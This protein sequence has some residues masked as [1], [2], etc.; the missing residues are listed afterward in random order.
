[1]MSAPLEACSSVLRAAFVVCAGRTTLDRVFERGALRL[2]RPHGAACEGMIVNTGGGIVAGDRLALDMSLSAQAEVTVTT[3]AAEKIYGSTGPTA[4]IETQLRLGA[5][6]RLDWLPQETILFDGARLDRRFA[7]DMA[8][9]AR[10]VAAEMVVFGRLAFGETATTGRLRDSWRLRRGGRLVFADETRLEGAIG[11]MLDRPAIAAGARAVA[12]L[13]SV[14]SDA[15]QLVDP[16]RAAL[17][18]FA[19]GDPA[20]RVEAGASVRDGI[21]VARLLAH[22][23]ERLRASMIAAMTVVRGSS[24]PSVWL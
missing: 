11:D 18:P 17:R 3:V 23:P 6:A 21:L 19:E 5:G 9:D 16:L 13:L 4:T 22:S 14:T 2:R 8:A 24:P 1:M 10:L 12:L 20:R 15:D 7:I